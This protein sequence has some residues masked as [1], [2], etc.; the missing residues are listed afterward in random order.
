MTVAP[1]PMPSPEEIAQLLED[2][3][4]VLALPPDHPESVAW[5]ARKRDIF[6]RIVAHYPR[7]ANVL[8]GK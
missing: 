5:L 6:A 4:P 3:V 1:P 7:I 2:L 8:K